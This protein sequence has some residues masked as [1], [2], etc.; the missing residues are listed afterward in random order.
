MAYTK[1][2]TLCITLYVLKNSKKNS[3]ST[4]GRKVKI[5]YRKQ[6]I[7]LIE[8]KLSESEALIPMISIGFVGD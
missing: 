3:K 8:A 1:C 6:L 4:E 5:A 7:Q 2:I